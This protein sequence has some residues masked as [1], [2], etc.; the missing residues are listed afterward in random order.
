MGTVA[1]VTEEEVA[2][3]ILLGGSC[4]GWGRSPLPKRQQVECGPQRLPEGSTELTI[5][6]NPT[7]RAAY[8]EEVP[9][10]ASSPI[11][12]KCGIYG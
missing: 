12:G 8:P 1:E 4:S 7:N 11:C 3:L 9:L 5:Q 6:G 2:V 10:G